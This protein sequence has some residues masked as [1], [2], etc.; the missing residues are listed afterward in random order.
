MYRERR[1]CC[2]VCETLHKSLTWVVCISLHPSQFLLV[3]SSLEYV[4]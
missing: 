4:L 1:V 3:L 2:V